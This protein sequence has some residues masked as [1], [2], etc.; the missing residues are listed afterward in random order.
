MTKRRLR[1]WLRAAHQHWPTADTDRAP[2]ATRVKS[3]K[4]LKN[5]LGST[6]KVKFL[7][8]GAA[9]ASEAVDGSAIVPELRQTSRWGIPISK[10]PPSVGFGRPHR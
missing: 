2:R 9:F 6:I 1:P 5:S 10:P 4:S 8:G 3:I 7:R